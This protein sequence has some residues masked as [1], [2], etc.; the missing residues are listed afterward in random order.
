MERFAEAVAAALAQRRNHPMTLVPPTAVV[1]GQTAALQQASATRLEHIA[2]ALLIDEN[3]NHALA[4]S[5]RG[6]RA[7]NRARLERARARH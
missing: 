2:G 5:G 3:E 6:N 7:V 1:H 4:N